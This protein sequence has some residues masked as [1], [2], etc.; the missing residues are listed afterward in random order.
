MV[1]NAVTL[2]L[3]PVPLVPG[4]VPSLPASS[5]VMLTVLLPLAI[6]ALSLLNERLCNNAFTAAD[7][8]PKV[9]RKTSVPLSVP[10]SVLTLLSMIVATVVP[11]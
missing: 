4:S 11:P 6:A 3:V 5:N 10:P 7:V 1:T 8:A 2:S 9:N